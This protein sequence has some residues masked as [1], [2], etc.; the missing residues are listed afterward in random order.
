MKYAHPDL[1]VREAPSLPYRGNYIGL[2]GQ[3]QLLS[4][5]YEIWEF[6]GG[7]PHVEFH[8]AGDGL[9]VSRVTGRA[10]LRATGQEV[11]FDVA[12]WFIL[13]DGLLAEII[14]YYWDAAPLLAAG[15]AENARR[16]LTPNP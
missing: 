6:E 8:D 4:D 7:A 15:W 14:V 3:R 1:I 10:K 11:D 5:V 9:V 12:E 13:R 16:P 2:E